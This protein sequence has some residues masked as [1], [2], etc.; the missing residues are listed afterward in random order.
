MQTLKNA[1]AGTNPLVDA[2][3]PD[4]DTI[5]LDQ[6]A[7]AYASGHIST[8][9]FL[10]SRESSPKTAAQAAWAKGW[11]HHGT[12]REAEKVVN[13]VNT[14]AFNLFRSQ[15]RTREITTLAPDVVIAP[16]T[17]DRLR[18][19]TGANR[20]RR[21]IFKCLVYKAVLMAFHVRY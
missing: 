15:F 10:I 4:G 5:T 2:S 9:H 20:R 21:T 11:E 18:S 6:L 19:R 1:A 12:L 7:A 3:S 16:Q 13:W 17:I 8:A 14:I